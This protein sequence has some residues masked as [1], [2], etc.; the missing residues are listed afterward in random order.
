MSS[1][2]GSRRRRPRRRRRRRPGSGLTGSYQTCSA[3]DRD[4]LPLRVAQR[5]Q[6]AAEHAAGVQAHVLLTHSG[7]GDRACGRRAPSPGRG[8]R[9]PTGSAP[10]GRTR[11]SRRWCRRTARSCAPGPTRGRGSASFSPACATT[12]RPSSSTSARPG[13]RTNSL[14]LGPELRAAR[15]PAAPASRPGRGVTC[16][17]RPRSA[18]TSLFSWL[19]GTQSAWPA[20]TMPITS[21]STPGV[22]GPRSTRSPRKTARRPSGWLRVDRPAR[23]RRGRARS[24][25]RRAASPARPGSRARRR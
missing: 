25:A 8:S 3:G 18:R 1:T 16:T 9:R 20:A 24:R 7:V 15:R 4:E 12:S 22:S 19:P 10:A 6:R 14:D 17:L 23:R 5:G 13:R 21:R 11:R 2:S